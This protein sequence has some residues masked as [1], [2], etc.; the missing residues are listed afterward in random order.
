M[1]DPPKR[2]PLLYSEVSTPV[3]DQT[4]PEHPR[5]PGVSAGPDKV[6]FS[7]SSVPHASPVIPSASISSGEMASSESI[8]RPCSSS[9]LLVGEQQKH[10]QQQSGS[11]SNS[12]ALG[13]RGSQAQS[14]AGSQRLQ[15]PRRGY[16]G[17]LEPGAAAVAATA[18]AAGLPGERASAGTVCKLPALAG[19]CA[20]RP[21]SA[22][23]RKQGRSSWVQATRN[24]WKGNLFEV[25][26]TLL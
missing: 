18:G 25:L 4:R 26:P 2:A 11:L 17:R 19:P 15:S 7:S 24:E 6:C 8:A 1:V 13:G 14:G 3:P 20:A 16:L 23:R 9:Y 21:P 10:H 12:R 5:R 22:P